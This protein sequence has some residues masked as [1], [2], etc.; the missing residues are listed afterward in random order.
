MLV[1]GWEKKSQYS[2]HAGHLDHA[3]E[4]HLAPTAAHAGSAEG[5]R[6][7]AGFG[8]E[9]GLRLEQRADLFRQS[10]ISPGPCGFQILDP[11]IHLFQPFTDRPHQIGNGLLAQ[12]QIA[13][14]GCLGTFERGLSEVQ[15]GLV[16][17]LQG[18]GGERLEGFG[19]FLAR[20]LQR[21][22]QFLI[23][24][25]LTLEPFC[26]DSFFGRPFRLGAF[27]GLARGRPEQ[28]PGQEH[29]YR[30]SEEETCCQLNVLHAPGIIARLRRAGLSSTHTRNSL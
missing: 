19:Q 12:V 2:Q 16:V 11:A 6:E 10:G 27:S 17:A 28:D 22:L 15:E 29:P 26:E 1:T 30:Q 8:P 4:L 7:P 3:L 13:A 23:L 21:G 24:L 9:L 20:V 5:R 18:L 14:G 25:F